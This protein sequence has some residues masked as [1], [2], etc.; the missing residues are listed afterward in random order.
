MASRSFFTL[1]IFSLMTG[2][3]LPEVSGQGSYTQADELYGLDQALC[4]GK[5]YVYESP[6]GSKGDQYL[7][8]AAYF[9]G[10]ATIRGK[11]YEGVFLNYDI[12]NQLLLMRY[13]DEMGTLFVIEVSKAW[14]EGFRLDSMQFEVR[15]PDRQI[16]QIIGDG[17]VKVRYKYHKNLDLEGNIGNLFFKFSR[18]FRESEVE[19]GETALPFHSNRSFIRIFAPEKRAPIK[20]YLHS[21]KINVK[22]ASDREMVRVVGFINTLP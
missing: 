16:F 20:E 19:R 5:K 17:P 10:S 13:V 1:L 4:S 11:R 6:A 14:L 18:P 21:R 9:K 15:G 12:F 2:L 22:K 7:V 3:I 8:S